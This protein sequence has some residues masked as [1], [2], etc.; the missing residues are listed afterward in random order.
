MH[1]CPMVMERCMYSTHSSAILVYTS[2]HQLMHLCGYS[3]PKKKK[4]L[5]TLLTGVL[6]SYMKD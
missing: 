6:P 2:Q 1:M 3:I 4:D 5:I